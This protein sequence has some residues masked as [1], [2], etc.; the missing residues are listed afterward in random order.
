VG[1]W[2]KFREK[3]LGK[4]EKKLENTTVKLSPK[5]VRIVDKSFEETSWKKLQ[6]NLRNK[7]TPFTLTH[8]DFH[9]SN[10]M[11][12]NPTK[13]TN[14]T[15]NTANTNNTTNTANT[16]N[17]STNSDN[18]PLLLLD[19]S[20]LSVWEPTTD[21]GQMVISDVKPSLWKNHEKEIF[22]EYWNTLIK[23]GVS[24]K[25]YSYEQ[26][27]Q[28]FCVAPVGKWI[29]FFAILADGFGLPDNAI[30]YFHD[31]ILEFIENHGNF[32]SYL[33]KTLAIFYGV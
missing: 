17:T 10:M 18:N 28:E 25:E 11:W 20:E 21:L 24:P 7:K 27:W 9:A 22:S 26:C 30:Q 33:V 32:P 5:F 2:A 15:T 3:K 13:I 16:N 6:E 12:K 1:N 14:T 31:Q 8:G 29:W 4:S 19:W 23:N